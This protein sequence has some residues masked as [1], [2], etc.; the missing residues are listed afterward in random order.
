[1]NQSYCPKCSTAEHRDTTKTY[2]CDV[3]GLITEPDVD[4][5]EHDETVRS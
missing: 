4:N 2:K 5:N 1:M 3:C